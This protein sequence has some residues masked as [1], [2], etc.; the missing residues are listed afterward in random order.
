MNRIISFAAFLL[1]AAA[2]T[3][4]GAGFR[5]SHLLALS[6]TAIIG[7]VYLLGCVEMLR[8]RG[9]TA[10]LQRA[11]KSA[12]EPS[13]SL[14]Q[15]LAKLPE[16]LQ[17]GIRL[18]IE[19]ERATLPGP[20]VTPYL[21]GLLVMLGMLGTFIGMVVTL[22]G[23]AFALEGTTDLEAIR[24]GLAA[25][26]KGL[27]QAFGTSVAGVAAS[28]M[29]GL[30]STLSRRDRSLALQALDRAIGTTFRSHSVAFQRQEAFRAMQTQAQSLPDVVD[31]LAAMATQMER[32]GLQ[33]NDRLLNNQEGFQASIK[34]VFSELA[35]S[36]EK[37]LTSSLS[38]TG[39][40]LGESLRPVVMDAMTGI[41]QE[42]KNT[43][44]ALMSSAQQQLESISG[45][46]AQTA[47]I[48]ANQWQS[49]LTEQTKLN[50]QL[51]QDLAQ[52][53]SGTTSRFDSVSN[54]LTQHYQNALE[55]MRTEQTAN[56]A[57]RMEAWQ[58][59]LQE[60]VATI[61]QECRQLVEQT[62]AQQQQMSNAFTAMSQDLATAQQASTR[63]LL[64]EVNQLLQTSE[65]QL[66]S[67]IQAEALWNE[68]LQQAQRSML[69]QTQSQR[70]ALQTHFQNMGSS[71]ITQWS[72]AVTQQMQLNAEMLSSLDASLARYDEKLAATTSTLLTQIASAAEA[73]QT[74]QLAQ[75]QQRLN[76][77]HDALSS[78]STVL[79]EEWQR[80]GAASL[81]QQQQVANQ[82]MQSA[83]EITGKATGQT[84]TMVDNITGM[85]GATENLIRARMTT[86]ETWLQQQN[87]RLATMTETLANELN[88]LRDLE[89]TRS[90]SAIDRL[91]ALEAGV[92]THLATL[93]SSLE[94]PMTRLIET[95]SE[96][97]RAAAEVIAQ[98]REEMTLNS[99]RENTLLE[100][101]N[102]LMESMD[103][104]LTSM[105][106]NAQEQRVAIGSLVDASTE[107]LQRVSEGFNQNVTAETGKL[108]EIAAQIAGS[109]IEVSSLS[110]AFGFAV[111]RFGEANEKLVDN[112][113]RIEA[114]LDK[115]SLRSDEQLA[116]YVAQAREI[117]DLS[118][119]SQKEIFDELRQIKKQAVAEV[120]VD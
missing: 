7:A 33:L 76:A 31:K 4:I 54:N 110:E 90:Q 107:S 21:V 23:A 60:T 113:G 48:V 10:A 6:V 39:H 16:A 80:A 66:Q 87:E 22:N 105:R 89:A 3:W 83:Q 19:G 61:T 35:S 104:L 52:S 45:R 86:E 63:E 29:L 74:T 8:F 13:L 109:T 46:F 40:L 85:L 112:L 73:A 27:G 14:D 88:A 64:Q 69:A 67:R 47:D 95:A 58:N 117:I 11:L 44:A 72:D 82:F 71:L 34:N 32:L 108:T 96:A 97:P 41:S 103:T 57:E 5:E 50:Q 17:G 18:R 56:D 15:W 92:A 115:S 37:S 42:A 116:Y 98:L 84:T 91:G 36:V 55:K 77:W 68:T 81:E 119:M 70:E 101:R 106:E 12:N 53:L 2:V 26:I 114:A 94:A 1:G 24:A 25:P 118:V 120:E 30:I 38:Q 102:R 79:K 49:T 51:T 75:D 62:T 93:G 59:R 99:Q 28:A 100:E 65:S 9:G 111:Q 43:Q 78:I 20:A